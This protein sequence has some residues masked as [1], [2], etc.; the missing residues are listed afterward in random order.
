MDSPRRI[1][2]VQLTVGLFGIAATGAAL[3]VAITRIDFRVPSLADL[4]LVFVNK[5]TY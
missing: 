2:L 3:V 4:V 5:A 1:W